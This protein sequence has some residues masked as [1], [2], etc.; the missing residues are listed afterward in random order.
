MDRR[1]ESTG[2]ELRGRHRTRDRPL[3]PRRSGRRRSRRASVHLRGQRRQCDRASRRPRRSGCGGALSGGRSVGGY[4]PRPGGERD[5]RL[6]T[7][8]ARL[9]RPLAASHSSCRA[10]G[11][12]VAAPLTAL[13]MVRASKGSEWQSRPARNG[14]ALGSPLPSRSD[15]LLASLRPGCRTRRAV[16]RAPGTSARP[17]IKAYFYDPT[18]EKARAVQARYIGASR[19]CGA[20]TQPRNGKGDAYAYCKRC[21]PGAIEGAGRGRCA[22]L[23]GEMTFRR[24]VPER[25]RGGIRGAAPRPHELSR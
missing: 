17:T 4:F 19:G 7:R 1:H 3:H 18:G 5:R 6:A 8:P 20:Y 22:V 10:V 21:H 2:S 11:G 12:V 13:T 16:A 25:A 24:S 23:V 15:P 14:G 9:N